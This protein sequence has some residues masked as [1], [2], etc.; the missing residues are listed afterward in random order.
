MSKVEELRKNYS[1]ISETTFKKFVNGDNTPTKKYLKYMLD[2]WMLKLNGYTSIPSAEILISQV[3]LFDSLLPYNPN[4]DIYSQEYRRFS[5]LANSNINISKI[6]EEKTFNRDEHISVIYEDDDILFLI[7][8]TFKGS[9]KYGANTKW[10]TAGQR[11]E[12]TFNSYTRAGFLAYLIDKKNEKKGNYNKLAFYCKEKNLILSGKIEIFNQVDTR[13]HN[14]SDLFGNGWDEEMIIKLIFKYRLRL[15]EE[16]KYEKSLSY[17]KKI[18]SFFKSFEYEKFIDNVQMIKEYDTNEYDK[19]K[20]D[21]K[22]L[23]E[24]IEQTTKGLKKFA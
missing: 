15:M 7:P 4:K 13:A 21:M 9:V 23:N 22:I 2:S 20:D 19:F 11:S 8:N 5:D 10:C 16:Q 3:K 17:V 6:K 18:T 24:I 14:E 12:T 1:R